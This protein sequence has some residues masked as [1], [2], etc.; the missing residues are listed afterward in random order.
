MNLESRVLRALPAYLLI[1][2]ASVV[3]LFP[4][5]VMLMMSTYV[6]EDLFTG[7]KLLPGTF[8]AENFR[9]VM[10]A[11]FHRFYMNSLTVAVVHT[12]SAVFVSA[13]TGYAFA[14]FEF[15]GKKGLFYFIL[16]SLMI[17]PQLGLV[18][19][20]MEIRAL[21]FG[22]TLWP[23]I[24]PGIANAFGTFWMTQYIRVAVPSEI[25]ESAMID[26]AST[27]RV[28]FQI[29]LPIIRAALVT[30]M[31][32]FFLWSWNNYLL[33]LVTISR[34]PLYTVPMAIGLIGS[35]YRTDFAARILA[36]TVSTLPVLLLFAIGSKHLIRG[37]TAGSV[38]G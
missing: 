13:L 15:K 1:G 22:N 33:P 14:K 27:M 5:Y 19:Y 35:E 18:G 32:L 12:T 36:L 21:G 28:F 16:G 23:L 10:K 30:L 38:K 31:L 11:Q 6:T 7:V 9:T 8:L 2:L 17:P 24:F 34:E 25:L 26:G 20:V 29:V 3:S 37:L 4:F